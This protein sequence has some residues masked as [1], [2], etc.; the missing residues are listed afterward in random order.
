MNSLSS[1]AVF[2][3]ARLSF[4]TLQ[5]PLSIGQVFGLLQYYADQLDQFFLAQQFKLVLAHF[6]AILPSSLAFSNPVSNVHASTHAFFVL[7]LNQDDSA[8]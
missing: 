8:A 4:S 2:A 6:V 5:S 7:A 3:I 1:S